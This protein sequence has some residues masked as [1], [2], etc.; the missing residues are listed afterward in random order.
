MKI[1]EDLTGLKEC[2]ERS[3]YAV[4]ICVPDD[5]A[6]CSEMLEDASRVA[7]ELFLEVRFFAVK[8]R[9]ASRIGWFIRPDVH[10]LICFFAG[11][12]LVKTLSSVRQYHGL[13]RELREVLKIDVREPVEA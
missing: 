13:L 4:L 5:D 2:I 6:I 11:G 1:L 3:R 9:D 10:P 7:R 12:R 8:R